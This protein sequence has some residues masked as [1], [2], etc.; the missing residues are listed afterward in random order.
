[1]SE[2]DTTRADDDKAG[3]VEPVVILRNSHGVEITEGG[4]LSGH[5]IAVRAKCIAGC[6]C[7]LI[8]APPVFGPEHKKGNPVMI[9][10]DH[11]AHSFMFKDLIAGNQQ[12][13]AGNKPPRD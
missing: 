9:C 12:Y 6:D 4:K 11:G 3:L 5:H 13:N 1:M 8:I 7:A 2:P 10:E